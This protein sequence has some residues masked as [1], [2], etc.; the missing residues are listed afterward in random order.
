M[1]EGLTGNEQLTTPLKHF[2]V[3]FVQFKVPILTL[4]SKTMK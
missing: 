4:Q 3:L 1:I 2:H